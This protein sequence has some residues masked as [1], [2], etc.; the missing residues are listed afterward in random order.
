MSWIAIKN[1]L[2]RP[3]WLNCDHIACV[4]PPDLNERRPEVG[5]VIELVT[6]QCAIKET[7][8]EVMALIV[9]F[10]SSTESGN[11]Q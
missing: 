2:D 11:R 7:V 6:G 10:G 1:L 8:D 4:R 5:S 3:V 9:K